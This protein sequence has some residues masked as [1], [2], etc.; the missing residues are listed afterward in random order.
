MR[1]SWVVQRESGWYVRLVRGQS[2]GSGKQADEEGNRELCEKANEVRESRFQCGDF[3]VFSPGFATYPS[4]GDN[5]FPHG[6]LMD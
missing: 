1:C 6:E 4:G 5:H 3:A 2:G